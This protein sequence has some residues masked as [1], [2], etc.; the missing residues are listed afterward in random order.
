LQDD[1]ESSEDEEI[2]SCYV[3]QSNYYAK[4]RKLQTSEKV[5]GLSRMSE[6]N[7]NCKSCS[8]DELIELSGMYPSEVVLPDPLY[9]D[10]P[11]LYNQER[12]RHRLQCEMLAERVE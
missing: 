3:H 10:L 12:E 1:V 9:R 6:M 7:L 2:L 11:P 8:I 4:L 5:I